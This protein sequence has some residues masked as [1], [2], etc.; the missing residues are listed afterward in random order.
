MITFFAL[1]S[2]ASVR[3]QIADWRD[4]SLP[5]L[6]HPV[7]AADLHITLAYL[8]E[9]QSWQLDALLSEAAQIGFQPLQIGLDHLGYWPKPRVVWLGASKVPPG[10][11]QLERRLRN[12]AGPLGLPTEERPHQPHLTL[13]RK[14]SYPPPAP[15]QTPN[16][17]PDFDS[18]VL[19]QSLRG[20]NGVRYQVIE[21]FS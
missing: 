19:M 11:L 15:T 4:A 12:L 10:L 6:K 18:F 1:Q 2:A 20:Q 8:G 7:A 3:R 16:F 21:T 17:L 13:A 5:P 9:T 14:L